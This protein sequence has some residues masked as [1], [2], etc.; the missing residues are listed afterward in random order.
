MSNI[1]DGAPFDEA[2]KTI[3]MGDNS[4]YKQQA[5]VKPRDDNANKLNTVNFNKELNEVKQ[6]YENIINELNKKLKTSY[7]KKEN[8]FE[9]FLNVN[10]SDKLNELITF[11]L[12]GAFIIILCNCMF[13]YG[14]NSI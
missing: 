2:F 1:L 5:A 7:S 9:N 13:N 14:K 8:L 12:I 10:S 6:K 11:I 4:N 3:G